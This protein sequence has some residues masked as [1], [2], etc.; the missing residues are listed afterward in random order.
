[1]SNLGKILNSGV[2]NDIE[3]L[4]DDVQNSGVLDPV[5]TS[6]FTLK[7]LSVQAANPALKV[8]DLAANVDASVQAQAQILA[9]TA[10]ITPFVSDASLS[11][12]N[13]SSYAQLTVTGNLGAGAGGNVGNAVP[14]SI[15]ASA[16]ASFAYNHYLPAAATSTRIAALQ[17]LATSAQLPQFESLTGLKAGEISSFEAKLNFDLGLKA[18]YGSSF[19]VAETLQLFEGLSAQFKAQVQYSIEASLGWS[20]FDDM[21]MVVGSAQQNNAGWARI[22]IDRTHRNS[23]TA[24][25]TFALQVNYDASSL[26][27]ALE[28]AFEMTPLPRVI[29][30]LDKAAT[31]SFS[32]L[33]QMVTDEA[34]NEVISLIAGTGWKTKAANAPTIVAAL[35]DINK[36]LSIYN[37]IDAKVQQL[38]SSLLTR[39]NLQP[40]SD[41][42]TTIE[43]IAALDPK[44][45]NLTQFLS[46]TAQK[47]LELLESLSG[48]SIEQL[49][50]GSNAGVEIAIS[51]AVNLAKQLLRV[52][53]DTPAKVNDAISQFET[54]FGIKSAV[55]F[56][57]N[58]SSLD[59]I[60]QFGDGIIKKLVSKAVGLAFNAIGQSEFDKVQAW[61]KKLIAQWDALSAKLA[62]AAKFLKGQLGFSVALEFSRVSTYSA[63]LDFEV[64]P[65]VAASVSAVQAQLPRGNVRDMLTALNGLDRTTFEIREAMIVSRHLRTGTTTV[66]LSLLG[67]QNLQK[68]MTT[69]FDESVI[70][71]TGAGRQASYSGGFVQAVNVGQSGECSTWIGADATD[72]QISISQPFASVSRSLRLTFAH[73]SMSSNQSERDALQQLLA[74][75]G[76]IPSTGAPGVDAADGAE[77]IFAMNIAL[78]AAAVTALV[79]DLSESNWNNDF[80]N[81]SVRLLRDALFDTRKLGN[82]D[83]RVVDA[84]DE[85]VGTP[86]WTD[87]WTDSSRQK[88]ITDPRSHQLSING[89]ALNVVSGAG[90]IPPYLELDQLIVRRPQGLKKLDD[91]QNAVNASASGAPDS[92]QKLASIAGTFF[93]N[94]S[95]DVAEN[96]MFGFWF[97]LARLTRIGA[98]ALQNAKGLA[99]L[100]VRTS[101][102]ADLSAPVQWTLTAGVGVPAAQLRAQF[103]F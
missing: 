53:N 34:T 16:S 29:E 43:A 93:A 71:I 9:S 27:D 82:V 57:S 81:S 102:T 39:V 6:A 77:T 41:L 2:V 97:V 87:T 49:L 3:V 65:Q 46:P 61:A 15:S 18:K 50:V 36:A 94:T 63:V 72:A 79:S 70:R 78:D 68:V 22:R 33:Q 52:I 60:E 100:R 35:A 21:K 28:K 13:G 30:I 7:N 17:Q 5:G 99:T 19:N 91:L 11:A 12:P 40:G 67:L 88:F 95:L 54:K 44:N 38:W 48:K 20:L 10:T 89:K 32:T 25:A 14:L 42:R 37:S 85:I 83:I 51:D 64:N 23:F 84:E 1:M 74:Q 4:F 76:F 59:K 98:A 69:R 31:T 86:L 55:T 47:N 96:P 58:I 73:H 56:L 26:A 45:P 92:L 90:I 8:F 24:G 62:A 80:R 75:L 101:P 103:P 66:I